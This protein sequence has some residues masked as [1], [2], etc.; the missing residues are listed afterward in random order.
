MEKSTVKTI[1]KL[2]AATIFLCF[3]LANLPEI[4][5]ILRK[6]VGLLPRF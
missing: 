6:L 5:G 2:I 1:M 4:L 3:A